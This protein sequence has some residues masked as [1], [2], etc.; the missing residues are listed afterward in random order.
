MKKHNILAL[1][2]DYMT[3]TE[4]CEFPPCIVVADLKKLT[5]KLSVMQVKYSCAYLLANPQAWILII[6]MSACDLLSLSALSGL[7]LKDNE[8]NSVSETEMEFIMNN[9]SNQIRKYY[10]SVQKLLSLHLLC[11]L[12]NTAV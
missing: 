1:L 6:L 11:R 4:E 2:A 10:F 3:F 12:L 5:R 7:K 9:D 8:D